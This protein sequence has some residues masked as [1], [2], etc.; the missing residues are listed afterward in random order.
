MVVAKAVS[1]KVDRP[2][3]VIRIGKRQV[4]PPVGFCQALLVFPEDH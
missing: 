4:R 1:A 3:G 2:A